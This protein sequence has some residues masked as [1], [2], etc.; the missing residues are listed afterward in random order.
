M[1][2]LLPAI[3]TETAPNPGCAVIWMH[4]LGADGSDFAPVVPELRLPA[5]PG[6]RF[7]FP[8]A[9]A[10]PVTCN[11]G[12]VMPAWYDIYSL[13]ESGRRA[14]EAGIRASCEAVRAL[15]AR[16]NAR[17]IPCSRIVLAGFSQGG[18]IAYTAGLTHPERLAG[19][20]ALSTYIPAPDALAAEATEAN[21]ATP[22][23]AAHGTQDD[24]VPLRLGTAARDFVQ[25]RQHP[26]TWQTYPMGHAVCLEEI[27]AIG[28]WLAERFAQA[29]AS[30]V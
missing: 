13:D 19:I 15:I 12:Y 16:E 10:M 1:S 11:G 26:V 7:I 5:S 21:A 23:F 18:A 29:E 8:H 4:G 27:M 28:A 20:V 22:V 14:D 3:E 9:P 17:G 25:A 6:V 30:Q 2:E 24:V